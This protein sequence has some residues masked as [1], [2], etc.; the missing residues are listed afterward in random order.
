MLVRD[1]SRIAGRPWLPSVEVA[2]GDILDRGSLERAL[3]GVDTAYYLVH[4][5]MTAGFQELD[6][7]AAETFVAAC[8]AA[9]R[10]IIY[11]GGLLPEGEQRSKHLRSRAEVGTILRASPLPVLEL[12]AGPIIGSGSASFEMLRYLTER[13]PAMVAPRWIDNLVQPISIPDRLLRLRA[14]MKVP[15]RAWLQWEVLVEGSATKLVQ[16]AIFSPRGLSGALYWYALYPLHARI[17]SDLARV[18][19]KE[20]EG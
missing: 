18:I 14:E 7:R 3:A 10:K 17:F 6:R 2:V 13:L 19:A 20:A 11:L 8:P 1:A 5:M 9:L 16:T 15:G 12:R 4:S